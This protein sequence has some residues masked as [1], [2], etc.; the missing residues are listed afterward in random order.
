[1]FCC[2][3]ALFVVPAAQAQIDAAAIAFTCTGCHGP[4]GK[5]RGSVPSLQALELDE[6]VK[7]LKE[8]KSG[9]QE[10]TIMG[11]IIGAYSEEEIK[12][13]ATLFAGRTKEEH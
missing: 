8:F 5:S 1:M 9:E 6:I 4:E 7:S 11:R 10:S 13:V 2:L 12:A 3:T